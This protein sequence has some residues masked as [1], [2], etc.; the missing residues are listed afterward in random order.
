MKT[1]CS[2]VGSRNNFLS[3]LVGIV[4]LTSFFF[5][6]SGKPALRAASVSKLP[7]T[8]EFLPPAL[9]AGNGTWNKEISAENVSHFG[10]GATPASRYVLRLH[11]CRNLPSRSEVDS[12]QQRMETN[13]D[14]SRRVVADKLKEL[15]AGGSDPALATIAT[16]YNTD[17]LT[18]WKIRIYHDEN[19]T[20]KSP[21]F[22]EVS[23]EG[24]LASKAD[25]EAAKAYLADHTVS[26]GKTALIK[27]FKADPAAMI[28]L[29]LN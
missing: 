5:L 11:I 24:I 1:S 18:V 29:G 15:V 10:G 25:F 2:P 4:V 19:I 16:D 23:L 3:V 17:G 21:D 14:E 12:F 26:A 13:T 28:I 9:M 20:V 8:A 7:V 6:N 22:F 27:A